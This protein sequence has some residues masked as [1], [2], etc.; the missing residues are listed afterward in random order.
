MNPI[1]PLDGIKPRTS[2]DLAIRSRGTFTLIA[3]VSLSC[4]EYLAFNLR[5]WGLLQR[6]GRERQLRLVIQILPFS[7]TLLITGSAPLLPTGRSLSSD[8]PGLGVLFPNTAKSDPSESRSVRTIP[9]CR[10]VGLLHN[11][12]SRAINDPHTSTLLLSAW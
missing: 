6:Y 8:N 4:G 7:N 9:I 5:V 10:Y 2:Q 1:R 3:A 12:H 11:Q